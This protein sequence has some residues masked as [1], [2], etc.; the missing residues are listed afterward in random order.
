MTHKIQ[1]GYWVVAYNPNWGIRFITQ[2]YQQGVRVMTPSPNLEFCVMT[3]RF[4]LRYWLMTY[5]PNWGDKCM[6][7]TCQQ[8]PCV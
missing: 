8:G 6:T 2:T 5:E 4:Q 1:M 7:Q 3:H